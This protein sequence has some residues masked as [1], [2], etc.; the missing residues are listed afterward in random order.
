MEFADGGDLFQ[1]VNEFKKKGVY[2]KE[3]EVW[4][5]AIQ[6]LR[7]IKFFLIL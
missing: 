3:K 2:I 6:M 7:G 4:D 1:K 5:L